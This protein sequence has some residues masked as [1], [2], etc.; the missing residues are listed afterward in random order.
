MSWKQLMAFVQSLAFVR[1]SAHFFSAMG[2]VALAGY[3]MEIWIAAGI[4]IAYTT[5]KELF[6]D[7]LPFGENHGSP[8]WLDWAF[9]L[10][11]VWFTCVVL[12]VTKR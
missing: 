5:F 8:D 1:Q 6:F 12:L 4:W 11:G 2:C 9:N 7:R 3:F 10:L